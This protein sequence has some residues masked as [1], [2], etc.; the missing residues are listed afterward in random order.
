M[1]QTYNDSRAELKLHYISFQAR[2]ISAAKREAEALTAKLRLTD[3]GYQAQLQALKDES[4]T[5]QAAA[6]ADIDT[7]QR[8]LK[9]KGRELKHLRQLSQRYLQQRSDIERFLLSSLDMV[10][11][12]AFKSTVNSLTHTDCGTGFVSSCMPA[13]GDYKLAPIYHNRCR[14]RLQLGTRFGPPLLRLAAAR[15][16]RATSTLRCEPSRM[17]SRALFLSKL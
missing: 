17:I 3:A 10:I 1:W 12:F 16:C 4:A 7:L 11:H 8:A 13:L 9:L 6:E 5:E 15:Q 2:G 14:Q